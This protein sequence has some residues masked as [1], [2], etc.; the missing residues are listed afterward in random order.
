MIRHP[1]SPIASHRGLFFAVLLGICGLAVMRVPLSA[2]PCSTTTPPCVTTSQYGN[3]RTGYNAY[4]TVLTSGSLESGTTLTQLSPLIVDTPPASI[5]ST[6]PIYAQPLYVA[7]ISLSPSAPSASQQYCNNLTINSQPACNMLL[8][9]TL[10]GSVWAYNADTGHVI[11]SRTKLWSSDCG[12]NSSI[13]VYGQGGLGSVPFAGIVATPVIDTT[14]SPPAMFLTSLCMDSQSDVHWYLHEID[15]TNQLQDVV[16]SGSPMEIS[17]SADGG[18]LTFAPGEVLQRPALLE[19]QNVGATPANVI[20]IAFGSAVP[21]APN[22]VTGENYPYHGWIFAYSTSGANNALVQDFAFSTTAAKGGTSGM[23]AC[24]SNGPLCGASGCEAGQY[25]NEP[26][27]CGHGSGIWMSGRGP[28][29][30]TVNGVSNAFFGASNG[31]FQPSSGNW[32]STILQFASAASGIAAN[33][34]SSFT[35]Q[36]GPK[37]PFTP[38]M[39]ANSSCPASVG[40]TPVQCPYTVD[41][42]NQN[43]WDVAI[44]GILLFEGSGQKNWLV[45]VDKAGHGYLLNASSLGGFTQNDLGDV[46]PFAAVASP[47]WSLGKVDASDCHRVISLASYVDTAVTAKPRYLYFWP[48]QEQLT[49]FQFSQNTLTSGVGTIATSGSAPPFTTVD[50]TT[51]CTARSATTPCFNG[52]IVAGD[53]LTAG[54]QVQ[55]VTSVSATSLTV[56]PGFSSSINTSSWTYNGYFIKPLSGNWPSTGTDV[57]YPGGTVTVTANAGNGG[58]VWTLATIETAPA[59]PPTKICPT[60]TAMLTAYNAPTLSKIWSSYNTSI[61]TGCNGPCFTINAPPPAN[62]CAAPSGSFA[63][64]T[65]VNGNA[66][67]PTYS[68]T[69]SSTDTA[70]TAAAPC[71]GIVVYCGTGTTACDGSW[72]Q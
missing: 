56:S 42:L 23:P 49:G 66:Y 38:P 40:G 62:Q 3:A 55:T 72:Q 36:G 13:P 26:N 28:A 70:C 18:T 30:S 12:P 5:G 11:F 39:L 6:N 1:Q 43:D 19:V 7:G 20:Y 4:E 17:G 57:S 15:L 25:Q 35:P 45:T 41:V 44:S 58:V 71:S 22:P 51:A 63:L 50:L 31:G 24:N 64:P 54:S 60:L 46:F 68:I 2:Q 65:I 9:V 52:Q 67:I 29:A 16:G 61:T 10:Y 32:G 69:S 34:S 21:E 47:C 33:P 27:W 48:F 8:A 37:E 14:L 53:T 59:N